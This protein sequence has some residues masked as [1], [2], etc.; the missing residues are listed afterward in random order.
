MSAPFLIHVAGV[1]G[2]GRGQRV[3]TVGLM[4]FC[5]H[6]EP[7]IAFGID[8]R[9]GDRIVGGMA[10]TVVGGVMQEGIPATEVRVQFHHRLRDEIGSAH[11]VGR[12]GSPPSAA[13]C[14]RC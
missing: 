2:V 4:R 8:D 3:P 5:D 12:G 10:P 14:C 6:R 1:R 11:N 9:D 7:V 13:R